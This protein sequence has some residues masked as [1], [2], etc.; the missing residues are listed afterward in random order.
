[1]LYDHVYAPLRPANL[2][3][4]LY[5]THLGA[6]NCGKFSPPNCVS[7]ASKMIFLFI[8]SPVFFAFPL[9]APFIFIFT[10]FAGN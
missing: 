5:D 10:D 4:T 9:A 8:V 1:M 7:H 6:F 3:C 2:H